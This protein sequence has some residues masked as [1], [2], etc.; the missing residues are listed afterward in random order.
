[1]AIFFTAFLSNKHQV[2]NILLDYEAS[3]SITES[4][5][6]D[7]MSELIYDATPPHS[8]SITDATACVGG[9][10]ASFMFYY[11]HV[12]AIEYDEMRAKYLYHNIQYIRDVNSKGPHQPGTVAVFKGDSSVPLPPP[13]VGNG[14]IF[15][16]PPWGGRDYMKGDN[17][18]LYLSGRDIQDICV[19][20][21]ATPIHVIALKVPINFDLTSFESAM[22]SVHFNVRK[23]GIG[24]RKGKNVFW[25]L[26][27]KK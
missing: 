2:T 3:Y 21:A 15:F 14:A 11:S 16:D 7:E 20:Y 27:C 19:G 18:H 10:T 5:L 22:R 25:L 12:N 1:V 13:I 17:I 9:N 26:I 24:Y 8:N 23:H 6:A 4:S